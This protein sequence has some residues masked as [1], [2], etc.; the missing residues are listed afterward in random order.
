MAVTMSSISCAVPEL[1][2]PV[3]PTS[4]FKTTV[5][6]GFRT[7]QLPL[8]IAEELLRK[9]LLNSDHFSGDVMSWNDL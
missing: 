1:P 7:W 2:L 6:L 8:G 5:A 9:V 3:I 4:K